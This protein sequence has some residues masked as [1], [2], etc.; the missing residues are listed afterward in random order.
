MTGKVYYL[1]RTTIKRLN[2]VLSREDEYMS[3]KLEAK[4]V[5]LKCGVFCCW[6][7]EW[8][9]FTIFLMKKSAKKFISYCGT[10]V[11]FT[12][13]MCFVWMLNHSTKTF[14]FKDI[15]ARTLI[16]FFFYFFGKQQVIMTVSGIF[17]LWLSLTSNINY[18]KFIG[19]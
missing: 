6:F 9:F 14:I 11:H 10:K 1:S 2:H 17:R 8:N 19:N 12:F 3:L 13:V 7:C 18:S 16:V 5:S 4:N 15:L